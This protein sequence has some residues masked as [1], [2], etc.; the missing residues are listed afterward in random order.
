[1]KPVKKGIVAIILSLFLWYHCGSKINFIKNISGENIKVPPTQKDMNGNLI[2]MIKKE[3]LFK[4]FPV[5]LESY[6]HYK[7]DQTILSKLKK[8]QNV[9]VLIIL[10]TWCSDSRRRVGEFLKIVDM[11]G[12]KWNIMLIG[13]DRE[14]KYP[15]E[16]I[17]QFNLEKVPT[18]IFYARKKTLGKIVENPVRTME[19]DILKIVSKTE[20]SSFE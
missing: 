18:F 16:I 8:Y 11:A 4:E 15:G 1:M 7:A 12:L 20:V 13:V 19:E 10:G 9:D 6:K 2:G 3:V 17:R 5:F 14:K